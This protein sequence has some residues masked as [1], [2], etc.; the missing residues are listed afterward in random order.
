MN[1]DALALPLASIQRDAAMRQD[2][3]HFL[4][5]PDRIYRLREAFENE[6]ERL[7]RRGFHPPGPDFS[8]YVVVR[9][10]TT[11][12]HEL[13]P[14]WVRGELD[15]NEITGAALFRLGEEAAIQGHPIWKSRFDELVREL[16]DLEFDARYDAHF[17]R[18]L[19]LADGPDDEEIEEIE[20]ICEIAEELHEDLGRGTGWC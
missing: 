2:F 4:E 17:A 8:A 5:N 9:S 16:G 20:D 3:I 15:D 7:S 6:F 14:I 11:N 10:N 19:E 18:M 12:E 1:T 13:L